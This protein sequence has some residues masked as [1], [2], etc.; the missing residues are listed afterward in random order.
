MLLPFLDK[1]APDST[2]GQRSTL[3]RI[4]AGLSDE[5]GS[6]PHGM[7]RS[8]PGI[9]L[10]DIGGNN[11]AKLDAVGDDDSSDIHTFADLTITADRGIKDPIPEY[12]SVSTGTGAI[13]ITYITV[14][15]SLDIK[16]I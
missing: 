8:I 7:M 3:V 14:I 4:A 2:L 10:F 1:Q 11:I 13:Y 5:G 6:N 15:T 12:I 16:N 9:D